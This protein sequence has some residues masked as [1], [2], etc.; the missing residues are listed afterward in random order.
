MIKPD[1]EF[2]API[3]R[4][5]VRIL[6]PK[7]FQAILNGV[8]KIEYRTLLQALLY[9]GMRY[10]EMK[11]FQKHPEWYDGD[12][13]HLP[14]EAVL[15]EKRTQAERWVRLNNQGRMIIQYFIQSK[16]QL[17]SYQ[18]WNVNLKRWGRNAGLSSDGL[19]VKTTRKTWES[20]LMFCHPT[21]IAMI[22][23]SQ[24]HTTLTSLQHYVN[25]PFTESDRI[26]IQ[27]YIQGW[28]PNDA[29]Y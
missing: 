20:W 22:T 4:Q 10:V 26:E 15:K 5:K 28:M 17:P 2:K 27:N 24:G 21:H 3:L 1:T 23:L 29:R 11:R 25:M 6:R 16:T 9:T 18:S 14:K 7:E 8:P 19:S 13:I 12:F